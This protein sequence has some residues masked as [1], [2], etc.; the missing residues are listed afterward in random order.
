MIREVRREELSDCAELIRKSFQT[1]ADEFG[2]TREN[3]PRFTAFATTE[4]RLIWQMES[5]HRLMYLDEEDDGVCGYYSLLLRDRNECE[6]GNLSVLPEFRHRGIGGRLL[7]HAI[8]TAGEQDCSVINLSIVEE[9]T[10]LR[11]WYE[12]YGAI[13]TGTEKFEFFPFTCGYMK[14]MLPGTG[15]G[16]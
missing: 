15:E 13:H 6:L 9:N 14:I 12:S 5:E 10:V 7:H 4:E 16:E 2:F 8:K 3:A 11:K 1:V